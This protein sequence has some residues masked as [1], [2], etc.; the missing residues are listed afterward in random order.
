MKERFALIPCVYLILEK[1]G[2]ILLLQRANT[3]FED[4]NYGLVSGHVHAGESM[5]AAMVREAK[6]E[7]GI[8]VAP[9]DLH[10][11]V[12]LHR[13]DGRYGI[14][15]FFTAERWEREPANMEPHVCS[16]LGWFELGN[17][18]PNTIDYVREAIGCFETG[19]TYV[20]F[21]F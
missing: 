21:G 4:G 6:E 14:D 19:K 5:T 2:K 8:E 1:D 17:L 9:E 18:P 10:V 16:D 12:T 15:I 20:E 11:V 7:A 13:N 3:G